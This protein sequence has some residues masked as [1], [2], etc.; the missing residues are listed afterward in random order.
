ME[1]KKSTDFLFYV[2][3]A[4]DTMFFE[5]LCYI[6]RYYKYWLGLI[7]ECL[8]KPS[9]AYRTLHLNTAIPAIIRCLAATNV[10]TSEVREFR[11]SEKHRNALIQWWPNKQTKLYDQHEI[12]NPKS[13]GASVVSTY[14]GK[15]TNKEPFRAFQSQILQN[16]YKNTRGPWKATPAMIKVRETGEINNFLYCIP[17]KSRNSFSKWKALS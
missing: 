10:P 16:N 1:I 7:N 13:L 2:S 8:W 11:I 15:S 14:V 3:N 4:I 9:V 17:V 5:Q 6:R 12:Q